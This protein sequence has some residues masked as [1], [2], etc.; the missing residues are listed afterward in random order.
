MIR[1]PLLATTLLLTAAAPAMAAERSFAVGSFE[2][3]RI[4]GPFDVT[5]ATDRS[6]GARATGDAR[7]LDRVIVR[8]DGTTLVVRW[9][10]QGWG[11]TPATR[12]APPALVLATPRLT[13]V[14]VA[15]GAKLSIDRLKGQRA[16][17]TVSGSGE[18]SVAGVD[19]DQLDATVIGPGAMT[20]AG[21]A[22]RARVTLNG[23][24]AID[25]AALSVSDLAVALDGPG[26]IAATARYTARITSNGRG[27]VTVAGTAACTVTA[28]VPDSVRCGK[29]PAPG[30]R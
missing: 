6:P 21:R 24:G 29:L 16:T 2:T 8:Q 23:T 27:T 28:I 15:S 3:L 12:G 18:L 20:L 10:S 4:E 1:R 9:S 26:T 30:A 19:A 11:E 14:S 5:L 17:L 7:L 22:A 25:A 13:N